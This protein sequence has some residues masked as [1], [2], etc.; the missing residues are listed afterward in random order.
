MEG[1]I[2]D[3]DQEIMET[4]EKNAFFVNIHLL[5]VFP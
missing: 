4:N 1:V 3:F 5:P 2:T